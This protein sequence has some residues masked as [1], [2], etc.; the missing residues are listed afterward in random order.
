[1]AAWG[2][3]TGIPASFVF[4]AS[5]LF[6]QLPL[7]QAGDVVSGVGVRPA[8]DGTYVGW[9]SYA[10]ITDGYIDIGSAP[11]ATT[12]WNVTPTCTPGGYNAGA[13]TNNP[14]SG[15]LPLIQDTAFNNYDYDTSFMG[16]DGSLDAGFAG[17]PLLA[18]P[19]MEYSPNLDITSL[20]VTSVTAV[21]VPA[22]AWL[23]GSGLFGLVGVARRRCRA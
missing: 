3:N 4:D 5:G 18:G 14:N 11:I 6:T 7:L 9:L 13:C 15:A 20:T 21:P 23:L 12:K 19:F 17:S 22:A 2:G 1:M 8:V 16:G 10:G